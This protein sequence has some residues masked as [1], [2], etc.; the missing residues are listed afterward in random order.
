MIRALT[1][2]IIPVRN[3]NEAV[4]RHLLQDLQV[5]GWPIIVV[6]DGSQPPC[7]LATLRH[8]FPL[9]YGMAI[10]SGVRKATTDLIATIDGDGQHRAWDLKRLEDFF[11]YFHGHPPHGSPRSQPLDMVIGDRRVREPRWQ[12]WLGR[13][14]LNWTAS[15]FAWRWIPDL[16]SGM[17]I[18]R[19]SIA[20]GYAPIL[21]NGFSY[22]TS[23]TLSMLADGYQVDW[24]P[25]KVLPRTIG[26][27]QVRLWRDGLRTLKCICWIGL[28]LRSRRLRSRLRHLW[29]TS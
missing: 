26:R 29:R 15:W 12:R 13:K 18:F 11:L 23:L 27:S 25:I 10:K 2:V 5:Y 22:T 8:A 1:T 20:E 9:G 14:L 7:S 24:L 17:R 16:N 3:E 4:V 28:G 19:R 21:S 6:D